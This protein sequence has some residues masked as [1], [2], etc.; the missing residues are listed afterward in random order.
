MTKKTS[1]NNRELPVSEE[2]FGKVTALTDIYNSRLTIEQEEISIELNVEVAR[3]RGATWQELGEVLGISRSAAQKR[4][5]SY[6]D[7]AMRPLQQMLVQQIKEAERAMEP[8]KQLIAQQIKD[9]ERAIE[10][11]KQ[12]IAQQLKGAE[13]AIR[14]IQQDLAKHFEAAKKAAKKNLGK[15]KDEADVDVEEEN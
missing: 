14:P 13:K 11:A 10:P 6:L 9:A 7:E 4:F 2:A 15:D 1:K 5:G 8:V 12:M 3:S